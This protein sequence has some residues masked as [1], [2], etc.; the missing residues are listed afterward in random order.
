M[1]YV[2]ID[3]G[4]ICA[5]G[6]VIGDLKELAGTVVM[7]SGTDHKATARAV[8]DALLSQARIAERDVAYVVSTGYGR[9][10]VPFAHKQITEIACHAKGAHTVLPEVQLVLD[11]GG[12]DC[13]VIKIDA[14]GRVLDFSMNDRCAAGTGRFLEVMA[15]ALGGGGNEV[16]APA[17]VPRRC[18]TISNMCAVFAES[19]VISKIAE[20]FT[21]EE[22]LGGI[23][24]AVADRVTGMMRKVGVD[25][26]IAMTGGVAK[27][28]GVVE[29]IEAKLG[30]PL[31][32]PENPQLVGAL[33]AAVLA[34]ENA[35]KADARKGA[36][37]GM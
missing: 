25:G 30:R 24:R 36:T 23:H 1:F 12:Q 27:N 7:P 10:N 2:G 17:D 29:A 3:V 20:G 21:K 31:S 35:T 15:T 32:I 22:I 18:V 28:A 11:I 33:G 5:K 8:L 4:S 19:E 14:A 13:K 9:S 16:P 34:L 6:A 37:G 26:S